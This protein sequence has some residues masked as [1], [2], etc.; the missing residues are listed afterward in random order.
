[1]AITRH[2]RLNVA[3]WTERNAGLSLRE[4]AYFSVVHVHIRS[5]RLR[6]QQKERKKEGVTTVLINMMKGIL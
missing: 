2:C 3:L 6:L 1:M 4:V 5:L